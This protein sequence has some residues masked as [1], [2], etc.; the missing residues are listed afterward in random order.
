MLRPPRIQ[1]IYKMK[2]T[3]T[4]HSGSIGKVLVGIHEDATKSCS[5]VELH[6]ML[7]HAHF[8]IFQSYCN[9]FI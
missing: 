7:M 6:T 3:T 2:N 1:N 4:G 5:M 8:S 9:V